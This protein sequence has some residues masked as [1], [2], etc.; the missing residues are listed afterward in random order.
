MKHLREAGLFGGGMVALSGSLAKRYNECLGLLGA[1]STKLKSFSIDGMGWSPEIALEKKDNFYLNS[2]QANVNA[3]I[4]SPQQKDKAVH[5]PSHSFDRDVMRAV[6]AAY[7]RQIR[8]ITKDAALVLHLDQKID[9]LIDPFDLLRYNEITVTFSLL[10]NLLEKQMEQQA[11]IGLFNR[12]NNFIDRE[13]H[14]KLLQSAK[15]YGD[16]RGRK[17]RLEP[18]RLPIGS[19]YTRAFGGVFVLRETMKE[20]LIFEDIKT[21]KAAINDTAHDILLFHKDHDELID[22]LVDHLILEQNMRKMVRSP[23]YERIKKHLFME[24]TPKTDRPIHEILR[25]RILFKKYLNKMDVTARKSITSP[26]LYFQKLIVDK[27]LKM[28]DM[29]SKAYIKALHTPHSSLK[30]EEKELA[31]KLLTKIMPKDPVYLYWYDKEQF[32]KAY[33]D[34]PEDYREWVIDE[35]LENNKKYAS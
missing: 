35:I 21:F 19:F 17:F 11:F 3:I 27:N 30:E 24:H 28:E 9:T 23:R 32:Y 4:I 31:W 10:G 29:V 6:F 33:L 7:A 13:V 16:L 34:W 1:T 20:M 15:K 14:Q 22:A 18:L 5:M 25:S 8:D 26:E 12:E 2:G